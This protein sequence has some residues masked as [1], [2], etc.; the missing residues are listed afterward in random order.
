VT[1]T[2]RGARLEVL[3]LNA[4]MSGAS[5]E[6]QPGHELEV[7]ITRMDADEGRIFAR[8]D[9]QKPAGQLPLMT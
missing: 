5:P 3:G 2:E 9:P 8:L 4:F 1:R 6:V 7:R